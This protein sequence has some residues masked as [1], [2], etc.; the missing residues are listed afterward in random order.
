[1]LPACC[2]ELHRAGRLSR[3]DAIDCC[4]PLWGRYSLVA[5]GRNDHL[6]QL[7]VQGQLGHDLPHL[8][9]RAASRRKP[10]ARVWPLCGACSCVRQAGQQQAR[11]AS[12]NTDLWTCRTQHGA[13]SLTGPY[14]PSTNPL[15]FL[16]PFQ[17]LDPSLSDAILSPPCLQNCSLA[18][19]LKAPSLHCTVCTLQSAGACSM[20][21]VQCSDEALSPAPSAPS[22]AAAA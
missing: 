6:G 17:R 20:Q 4:W 2:A 7:R 14:T 13:P 1:M 5:G 15:D 18:A 16:M 11:S 8:L 12:K 3:A 21:A 19:R 9:S 10:S 22:V